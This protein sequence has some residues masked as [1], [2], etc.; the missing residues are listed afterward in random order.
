MERS[1]LV[2]LSRWRF[3]I[4]GSAVVPG[5][6]TCAGAMA[7]IGVSFAFSLQVGVLIDGREGPALLQTLDDWGS[8]MM[9]ILVHLKNDFAVLLF[10]QLD[11]ILGSWVVSL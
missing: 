1:R 10:V 4:L 5:R 6:C 3:Y 7:D 2:R 8:D 9:F 11:Q